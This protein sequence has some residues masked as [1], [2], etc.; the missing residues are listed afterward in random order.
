MWSVWLIF[1]DCGFHSV[2]PL[3]DE[4]KR[5]VEAS[6]IMGIRKPTIVAGESI[7]YSGII[8]FFS[9]VPFSHS[10]LSVQHQLLAFTQTHVHWVGDAIQSYH[11]LSPSPP[12]LN[13]SQIRVI[14]DESVLCIRWPNIGVSASESVLPMSIQGWFPLAWAGWISNKN[15]TRSWLWL[16]SWT[17]YYQIQT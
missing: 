11:P 5:L 13:L 2:C 4:V 14:S 7:S 15:K 17:P 8:P 16:R 3:M 10:G 6:C 9:S 12:A 1:C